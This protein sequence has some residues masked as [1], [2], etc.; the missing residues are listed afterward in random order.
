MGRMAI[1][2]QGFEKLKDE[3]KKLKTIERPQIIEEIQRARAFGDLAEN[4][5]YHTAREKQGLLEMKIGEIEAKLSNVEII[6]REN[7]NYTTCAF[8]AFVTIEDLE[9]QERKTYQLVS[10]FESNIKEGKLAIQSPLAKQL[11]GKAVGEII[12]LSL[13]KS[14]KEFEIIK[15]W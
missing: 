13:A 2:K 7:Q 6:E 4:A 3:L 10:E 9:T 11:I 5:E 15:I 1:T 12:M 14:D 8:G